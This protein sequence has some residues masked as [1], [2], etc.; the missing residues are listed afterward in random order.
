M[1]TCLF[2]LASCSGGGDDAGRD[3]DRPASTTTSTAPPTTTT[4][5]PPS[6]GLVKA[7]CADTLV[8]KAEPPIVSPLL[9]EVSGVAPSPSGSD[10]TWLLNDSGDQPRLYGIG[11][12]QSVHVVSVTGAEAVDWEDLGA[13]FD[14]KNQPVLWIADTGANIAPRE[15]V[16]LYRVPEPGPTDTT[17]AAFAV[18]VRY[19]DG[20]H[21]AEAVLVDPKG[22][23]LIATKDPGRSRLFQVDIPTK[24][25]VVMAKE[26]GSFAPSGR[27]STLVTSASVAPDRHA[28]AIRTYGSVWLYE[29]RGEEPLQAALARPGCRGLTGEEVQGESVGIRR[30]GTYVTI[31]EGTNPHLT[32]ISPG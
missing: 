22:P 4:T 3:G 27:D 28:V 5:T 1:A 7:G 25:G 19:P 8:A 10:V 32:V 20:S 18:E 31:G 29:V 6:I 21:D 11:P 9:S 13:G 2:A 30:D 16:T 24:P 15:S 14:E 23:L 26:V 17:V 12:D